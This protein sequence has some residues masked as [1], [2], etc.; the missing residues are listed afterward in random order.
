MSDRY[1][2]VKTSR[3]YNGGEV[4]AATHRLGREAATLDEAIKLAQDTHNPVG[5]DV[6]KYCPPGRGYQQPVWRHSI[7]S[8]L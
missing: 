7:K 8:V 3:Y 5:F 4:T 2:L 6:Y 1:V